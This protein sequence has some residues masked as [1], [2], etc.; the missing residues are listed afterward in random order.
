MKLNQK[1]FEMIEE[2]H[3]IRMEDIDNLKDFISQLN[4][5]DY[6]CKISEDTNYLLIFKN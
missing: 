1:L 3:K 6:N 5:L 4:K 2:L